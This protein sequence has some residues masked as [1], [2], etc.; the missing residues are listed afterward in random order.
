MQK[1]WL[2][3]FRLILLP[4]S[5]FKTTICTISHSIQLALT[6][7]TG[8][9]PYPYN[10]GPSIRI[11][12]FHEAATSAKEFLGEIANHFFS[13]P[14]L[15]ALFPELAPK[16]GDRANVT[17]L[18]LPRTGVYWKEPTFE[19]L[20]VGSKSQGRHYNVLKPDDFYGIEARDSEAVHASTIRWVSALE[21]LLV[22]PATDRIDFAG[23]RYKFD[24]GYQHLMKV[25]GTEMKYYIRSVWE[26]NKE[27]K[28]E[29]I[30]PERFTI[31]SLRRLKEGDADNFYANYL[32]NPGEGETTFKEEHIR[33]YE[34]LKDGD[35]TYFSNS[36]PKRENV[37]NMHRIMFFDPA[38]SGHSGIVVTGTNSEKFPKVFVLEAQQPKKRTEDLL[39]Y[40]FSLARKWKINTLVV[41]KVLFSE[42]YEPLLVR[43]MREKRVFF[44]L[45][46]V[47]TRQQMKEERVKG[48][49]PWLANEQI[50]FHEDQQLL[51]QQVRQFGLIKE[52]HMLDAMAY[53]VHFWKSSVGQ[54]V[55]E[56]RRE[57]EERMLKARNPRTGYSKVG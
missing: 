2:D 28:L 10:L 51:L 29:T 26:R 9:L 15:L 46:M 47:T 5:H 3:Q 11:A 56:K 40:L 52:Y 27:G 39:N 19:A 49:A 41:E 21:S 57:I 24:D 30:F 38:T 34:R 7:D 13:N 4:R 53:G 32:N 12:L 54:E 33:Y 45:E 8:K 6:D 43:M 14:I 16:K 37:W 50:W 35:I 31:E 17:Q 25:Y 48:L 44:E 1:T 42:L 22:T 55:V 23:T 36:G 20:G 18:D